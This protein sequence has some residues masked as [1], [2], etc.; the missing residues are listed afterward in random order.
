MSPS[1]ASHATTSQATKKS[2]KEGNSD[3]VEINLKVY[4]NH[5][6]LYFYY[7]ILMSVSYI[8]VMHVGYLLPSQSGS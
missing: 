4:I 6:C 3:G 5:S 7:F 1:S 8:C 2:R